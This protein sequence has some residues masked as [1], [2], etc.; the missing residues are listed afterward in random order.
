MSNKYY[1][2]P[3]TSP[4][5]TAQHSKCIQ[6]HMVLAAGLPR[7]AALAVTIRKCIGDFP[8]FPCV[9]D[10]DRTVGLRWVENKTP[11]AHI[12]SGQLQ[13][14]MRLYYVSCMTR[15][16]DKSVIRAFL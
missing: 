11:I 3:L 6:P 5:P 15:T 9:N 10:L 14:D 12:V 4:S 7:A 1:I 2:V 13:V 16:V 8:V